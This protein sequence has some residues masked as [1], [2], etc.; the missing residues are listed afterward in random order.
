MLGKSQTSSHTRMAANRAH[1]NQGPQDSTADQIR[2]QQQTR[3]C[4]FSIVDRLHWKV[5]AMGAD[6]SS[7][8]AEDSQSKTQ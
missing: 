7:V 1:R 6:R 2:C 8:L 4:E 5:R 3:M